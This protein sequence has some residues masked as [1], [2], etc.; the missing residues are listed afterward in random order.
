MMR[1][2]MRFEVPGRFEVLEPVGA[3]GT[4]AVYR[5]RDHQTGAEVALKV[6]R[7]LSELDARRLDREAEAL[8][9]VAHDGIVGYLAHG[10]TEGGSLYLAMEW[11]EGPPL[12][13]VLRRER[14]GVDAVARLGRGIAAALASA[15]ARGV[16]HRDLKPQNVILVHGAVDR[17]K[18]VDF[19]LAKVWTDA[20]ASTL[21]HTGLVVG[22]PAYMAP[23]QARGSGDVDHRADA[24][25]LGCILFESLTGAPP[26]F[27][28]HVW[29][30]LA[31]VLFDD[32]VDVRD[33]RPETP[34]EL[35]EL[36]ARLLAK[37]PARRPT[38]VEVGDALSGLT[39]PARSGRAL[40]TRQFA[41]SSSDKRLVSVVVV[42]VAADGPDTIVDSAPLASG[43]AGGDGARDTL[44]L[45]RAA[46]ARYGANV[47]QLAARHVVAVLCGEGAASDLAA[48]AA[49]CALAIRERIEDDP[50]VLA[51]GAAIV[52]GRLPVGEII[53]HAARLLAQPIDPDA[54]GGV[55]V[56]L[57][58]VTAGLLDTRFEV[59][60]SGPAIE[61]WGERRSQVAVRTLMGRPAPFVG[62]DRELLMLEAVLAEVEVES[63]ARVVL[64]TGDIGVGKSRLRHEL[65]TRLAHRGQLERVWIGRGDPMSA[66]SPFGIVAQALR[67]ALGLVEGVAVDTLRDQ[68]HEQ[69]AALIPPPELRRVRDFL[70]EL[71]DVPFSADG[72]LALASARRDPVLMGD[73]VRHAF[74]D[75]LGASARRG[76]VVLI[77]EDLHWGD[78]SS[79]HLVESA[80]GALDDHPIAVIALGRLTV[81]SLFPELWDKLGCVRLPL[82]GLS[83]RACERMVRAVLPQI[84]DDDV[85]TIL[86]RA[87]GNA[88]LLEELTRCV[89]E[90]QTELPAT[91]LAVTQAR[92][93]TLD[94][95]GRRVVRAAS[96]FGNAFW[97]GGI[98]ALLSPGT[99]EAA[100]YRQLAALDD[101]ELITSR[102]SSR[103]AGEREY[104]FRHVLLREAAYTALPDDDRRL[105]HRLAA[106][107]LARH[108]ETD[109]MML[110]EHFDRGGIGEHAA[111][112]YHRAAV[113]ALAGNDYAAV[114]DR[115]ARACRL[116]EDGH[117]LGRLLALDAEAHR[118]NAEYAEA[119][120]VARRALER[121]AKGSAEWVDVAGEAAHSAA[122]ADDLTFAE[123]VAR[124]LCELS[125]APECLTAWTAA[126][127]KLAARLLLAERIGWADRLLAVLA[128]APAA[129]AGIA[130]AWLSRAHSLRASATD[131]AMAPRLMGESAAAFAEAGDDRNAAVQ[132][133]NQVEG[134]CEL[135][136]FDDA[137]AVL[138]SVE[139]IA[140][141]LPPTFRYHALDARALIAIYADRPAVCPPLSAAELARVP[142]SRNAGLLFLDLAEVRRRGGQLEEAR[143]LAERSV[144]ILDAYPATA[145]GA[146][147][148]CARIALDQGR[149]A[150]ALVAA[151][152]AATASAGDAIDTR[153]TLVRIAHILALEANGRTADA[154]RAAAHARHAIEAEAAKIT[155]AAQ[156][157]AFTDGISIHRELLAADRRLNPRST[158]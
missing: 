32:P 19:G 73:Q 112:C 97:R 100:I 82:K 99:P 42:G 89:A 131:R 68:L 140:A 111:R 145:A 129:D 28:A 21:T 15:H 132:R 118:W 58:Q 50:I 78:L 20:A 133:I 30:T 69:L 81:T 43:R 71:L 70:G 85:T 113:E 40:R 151:E 116:T 146:L 23:E 35:A 25:A 136:A 104:V 12:A 139:A 110:A 72:H 96:V 155:D 65:V 130:R 66:G 88:F 103:I 95:A 51:T 61:L 114:H 101:R 142:E 63:V 34:P 144:A 36:V 53:D 117:L 115:V 1:D 93:D 59:S 124:D 46:T 27:A 2:R 49:R 152:R 102:S 54:A 158:R 84:G 77:L 153:I 5:A 41:P 98:V 38:A 92:L 109:P 56:L 67:G 150:D 29:A 127:A 44:T 83:R 121:F 47:E 18:L 79:V 4:A 157:A 7:G 62:R 141:R 52:A 122:L 11:I 137:L 48:N 37:D 126:C 60:Q 108:G 134:L 149:T 22:T 13:R 147:A 135:A 105:G 31:K 6:L 87:A 39:L 148:V 143:R 106:D 8:A 123:D 128:A 107:W 138:A 3:G 86:D 55:P 90:G 14:L 9:S 57:D 17:P 80:L 76:P 156:R 16:V 10:R 74:Q 119:A 45:V 94:A 120:H 125:P 26:F 64:V 24:F 91:A 33:A 154:A 75:F